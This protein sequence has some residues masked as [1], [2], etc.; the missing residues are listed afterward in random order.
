VPPSTHVFFKVAGTLKLRFH[1]VR[2]IA[3]AV[4][5]LDRFRHFLPVVV[6]AAAALL[7]EPG[8]KVCHNRALQQ[9]RGFR[10]ELV[11]PNHVITG[12]VQIPQQGTAGVDFDVSAARQALL[13][14]GE[15]VQVELDEV[16]RRRSVFAGY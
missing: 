7:L 11:F 10:I 16:V 8:N 9:R 3:H 4:Q 5:Y 15:H 6:A 14:F 13:R 12:S 2:V 1:D